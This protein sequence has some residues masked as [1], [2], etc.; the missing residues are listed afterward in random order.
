MDSIKPA[1]RGMKPEQVSEPRVV[2]TSM[3]RAMMQS[4]EVELKR[5]GSEARREILGDSRVEA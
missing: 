5:N 4:C 2:I 1:Q 3:N